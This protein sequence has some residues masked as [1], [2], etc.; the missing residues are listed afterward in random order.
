MSTELTWPDV[1]ETRRAN[2][3]ASW[4]DGTASDL[5]LEYLRSFFGQDATVLPVLL[6]E[7]LLNVAPWT[8]EWICWLADSLKRLAAAD[9][10]ERLRKRLIDPD[11]FM[12]AWSVLQVAE[13]AQSTGFQIGFDVQINKKV[14]DLLLRDPARQLSFICEVSVLFSANAHRKSSVLLD[15]IFRSLLLHPDD[16]LVYAGCILPGAWDGDADGL[17]NRV[18][19]E[20]MGMR[21]DQSFREVSVE[22]VLTLGFAPEAQSDRVSSWAKAHGVELGELCALPP[23]IDQLERLRKKIADKTSQLS[24]DAPNLLVIWA[25]D[26]F[27]SVQSP[28]DLALFTTGMISAYPR[29]AALVIVCEGPSVGFVSHR[30]LGDIRLFASCRGGIESQYLVAINGACPY[31]LPDGTVGKLFAAFSL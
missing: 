8:Y 1:L 7:R 6:L 11:K 2:Q 20:I 12:E 21:R 26:L 5:P 3:S 28:A 23:A 4:V 14:P 30:D 25:Q 17:V 10:F 13:R 9:G 24:P 19:W 27:I 29:V 22:N 18:E 15:R 31:K 16:R